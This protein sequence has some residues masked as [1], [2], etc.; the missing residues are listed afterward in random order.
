MSRIRGV[1][2]AIGD[3][4]TEG[5]SDREEARRRIEICKTCEFVSKNNRWCNKCGCWLAAKA[6]VRKKRCALGKWG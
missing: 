6:R 5:L 1:I 3:V 2:Q 4:A